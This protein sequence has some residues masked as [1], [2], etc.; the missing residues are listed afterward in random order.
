MERPGPHPVCFN[1]IFFRRGVYK[2]RRREKRNPPFSFLLIS[3]NVLAQLCPPRSLGCLAVEFG[4]HCVFQ[5]PRYAIQGSDLREKNNTDRHQCA[6]KVIMFWIARKKK[7]NYPPSPVFSQ[8]QSLAPVLK[9][10]EVRPPLFLLPQY[11]CNHET[12]Y[13]ASCFVK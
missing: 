5:L 2:E 8:I 12:Q 11:L 1:G 3:Q 7:N 13:G 9:R 10:R 6:F 4:T